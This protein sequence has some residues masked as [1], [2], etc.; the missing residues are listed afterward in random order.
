MYNSNT[1][2]THDCVKTFK[3]HLQ[4]DTWSYY[5]L[6]LLM[7]VYDIQSLVDHNKYYMNETV[8][9]FFMPNV[10]R[11]FLNITIQ[12][13]CHRF[14]NGLSSTFLE[15]ERDIDDIFEEINAYIP[16]FTTRSDT[17]TN[18]EK[19]WI[20][21]DAFMVVSGLVTAYRI[22]K[23]ITFRKNVQQPLSYI[24]D[25]QKHFQHNV[26]S[27]KRYLLSLEEITLLCQESDS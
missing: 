21:R 15:F 24:L 14:N 9:N 6:H 3:H 10:Y 26:L 4:N 23:S 11:L 19:H 2:N 27:N 25:K 16:Q 12:H 8:L 1:L 22:Y 20:F 13:V 17:P 7:D 18:R 5:T